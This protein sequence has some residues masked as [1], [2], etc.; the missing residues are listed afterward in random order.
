MNITAPGENSAL[1]SGL[2]VIVMPSNRLFRIFL[3]SALLLSS[4]SVRS[5]ASDGVPSYEEN[6]RPIIEAKCVRCHGDKVRKAD[7]DLRTL[8]A[9]IQGGDSGAVV[10]PGKPDKS[11]L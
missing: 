4:N 2:I 10:V 9:I 5:L 7:L 1:A 11:L 3:F 6:L 8:E